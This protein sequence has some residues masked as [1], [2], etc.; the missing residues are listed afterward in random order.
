MPRSPRPPTPG[1]AREAWA[2]VIGMVKAARGKYLAEFELTPAQ[3]QLLISLDAGRPA[4]MSELAGALGCDAS[5][6]TGLVDRLEA[7]QLIE[8]RADPGDRRVKM[9]A[10]TDAGCRV[11]DRLHDRWFEPPPAIAGL[12]VREQKALLAILKRA[13]AAAERPA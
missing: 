9:V 11:K 6:V 13:A 4:P 10:V 7:R 3:A 8:R 12:P 1:P 2:I 5:N